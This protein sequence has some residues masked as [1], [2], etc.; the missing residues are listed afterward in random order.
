MANN[1]VQ[2]DYSSFV[3]MINENPNEALIR[4][5]CGKSDGYTARCPRIVDCPTCLAIIKKNEPPQDRVIRDVTSLLETNAIERSV[6]V[7]ISKSANLWYMKHEGSRGLWL[8][9]DGTMVTMDK[10]TAEE[11]FLVASALPILVRSLIDSAEM[12]INSMQSSVNT[13]KAAAGM[14]ARE[15]VRS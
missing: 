4:G 10:A 9:R 8:C 15:E 14:W 3:H 13:I 7:S 12:H 2:L 11:R 1:T 6:C 5:L